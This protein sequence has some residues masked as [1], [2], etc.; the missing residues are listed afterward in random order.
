MLKPIMLKL[1]SSN[2]LL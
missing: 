2:G 1:D